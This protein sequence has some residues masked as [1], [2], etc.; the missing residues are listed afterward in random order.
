MKGLCVD[1]NIDYS[2]AGTA[3]VAG[4]TKIGYKDPPCRECQYTL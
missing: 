1:V 4:V 2:F 3:E